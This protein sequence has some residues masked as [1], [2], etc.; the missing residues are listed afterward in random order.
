MAW[1]IISG[2]NDKIAVTYVD[3]CLEETDVGVSDWLLLKCGITS[4]W[5]DHFV[6]L[7]NTELYHWKYLE[8]N[9]DVNGWNY[10]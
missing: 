6:V 1:L 4:L 3:S 7:T 5:A 2:V 9:K 8:I 10:S